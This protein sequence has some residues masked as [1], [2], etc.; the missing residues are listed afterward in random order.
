MSLRHAV[1]AALLDG[2]ASGY[3]MAKNFDVAVSNYWHA[4]PQ[5]LYGELTRLEAGGLVS[6]R[7]VVQ[8]GRPNKRVFHLTEAGREELAAFISRPSKVS[9]IREELLVK[10]QA[11]EGGDALALADQ[12]DERAMTALGKIALFGKL[13]ARLR[14]DLDETTFLAESSRIGPYLT[15]LRGLAFEQ[16]NLEWFTWTAEVLRARANGTTV[17]RRPRPISADQPSG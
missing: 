17:P 16:E 4:L 5:Q 13:L 12:L 3:Q 11:V 1:L 7:D 8:T 10:V 9:F 2:E 6:G 14:G 15:G